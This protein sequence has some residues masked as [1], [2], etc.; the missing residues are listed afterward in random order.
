MDSAL[1]LPA[2]K[3]RITFCL[4]LIEVMSKNM[5]NN[6]IQKILYEL[7]E[8]DE[9]NEESIIEEFKK[10]Q[11]SKEELQEKIHKL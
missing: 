1:S 7:L 9:I 5:T 11:I 2:K 10:Q 6:D 3:N 8:T 4:H